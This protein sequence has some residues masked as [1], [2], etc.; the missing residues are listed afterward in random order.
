MEYN[1]LVGDYI[2]DI[3]TGPKKY[4]Y[5]R[6]KYN[7]YLNEKFDK[8]IIRKYDRRVSERKKLE[9]L[10]S[11]CSYFNSSTYNNETAIFYKYHFVGMMWFP[12]TSKKQWNDVI[13][14]NTEISYKKYGV[15]PN[16]IRYSYKKY[17]G[18]M[19]TPDTSKK[20]LDE[21]NKYC[22]DT[23]GERAFYYINDCGGI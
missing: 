2:D 21:I 20:Y 11:M 8:K 13:D 6:F 3:S 9:K 22:F 10:I 19:I 12:Y 15:N 18:L 16:F 17:I 23:I 1:D 7:V 4:G 14:L 5:V